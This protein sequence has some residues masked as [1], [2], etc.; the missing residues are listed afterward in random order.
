MLIIMNSLLGVICDT[1][2]AQDCFLRGR[3][4]LSCSEN[5]CCYIGGA[6][7]FHVYYNIV[8]NWK[9]CPVK[10]KYFIKQITGD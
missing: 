7:I 5:V 6:V 3:F 9:S 2:L 1:E 10:S 4:D 8:P